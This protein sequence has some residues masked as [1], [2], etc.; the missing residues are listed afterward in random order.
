MQDLLENL[1]KIRELTKTVV[2]FSY[3]VDDIELKDMSGDV[4]GKL[5]P[6]HKE[7]DFAV[8]IA[9][10]KKGFIHKN[11]F[12]NEYEILSLLSGKATAVFENFVIELEL[13]KPIIIEPNKQHQT[14]YFEDSRILA[15]TL[16][17]SK[18]FPDGK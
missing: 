6:I 17:A 12:H 15:I 4:E 2:P 5:I 11:H 1:E 8:L 10:V 9:D 16:P 13:H 7:K 18:E 14:H 3:T